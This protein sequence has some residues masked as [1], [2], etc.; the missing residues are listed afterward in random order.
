[1][2]RRTFLVITLLVTVL[3]FSCSKKEVPENY[4]RVKPLDGGKLLEVIG[5]TENKQIVDIP[6]QLHGIPVIGIGKAAFQKRELIRATI[7]VSLTMI[8]D[9]AF[10]ENM[11]TNVNLGGS[12]TTI[13]IEAFANN[14]LVKL[15]IGGSVTDIGDRAF[16]GNQIAGITIPNSIISIGEKAFFNNNISSINIPKSLTSI[17]LEAFAGNPITSLS[18]ASGSTAFITN[19]SCLFSKDGSQLVFYYGG[20]KNVAIPQGAKTIGAGAFSTRQLTGIVIPNGV[21]TIENKA[22][23]SN[24]LTA[25]KIPDSVTTIGDGAF[26]D[27]QI[28]SITIGTGVNIGRSSFDDNNFYYAYSNYGRRA[29]TY[30]LRN[31][32]WSRQQ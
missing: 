1:M 23:F 22:F 6:S 25:I 7:P 4:F 19:E 29:G 31:G 17:G 32:Y 26:F 24:E 14:M 20:E 2:N 9:R 8:G 28:T 12:V 30:I 21:I 3:V 10:A 15:N 11:L 13:G 27:N 18:L 16:I 5:Y